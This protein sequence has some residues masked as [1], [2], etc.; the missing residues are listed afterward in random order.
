MFYVP[1]T[2]LDQL[3]LDDIQY[4]DLTTRALGIGHQVGEISFIRREAGRVSGVDLVSKLLQKCDL[5]AQILVSDGQ[6]AHSG[7]TL[8]TAQGS[9]AALQQVWKV[10]QNVL[11]WSCGVANEM[12]LMLHT[13]RQCH[14]L[15]QIACTR[16]NIPGTKLLAIMA[17]THGGGIIHR[18]GTAETIL[19][20]ANHRCF[21]PDPDNWQQQI[22]QLRRAAP[23]KQIIVEADN[24]DEAQQ[25]LIAQPDILQLDKFSPEQIAQLQQY[26]AHVA[27][28]CQ[29]SVAGGITQQN[30]ADYA[31]TGIS[32]IVTS[33]PYYAKPTDIK[34]RLRPVSKISTVTR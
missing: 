4:G 17:I 15:I 31:K 21:W 12:A 8:L 24:R 3:L 11:E 29:L 10:S 26:A 23:E 22:T 16:K 5:T 2:F 27:P 25:A 20:F 6:D 13:A 7:Q 33:A 18:T 34:V 14:P 1:D 19:L 28:R 9:V 30:I 32:L